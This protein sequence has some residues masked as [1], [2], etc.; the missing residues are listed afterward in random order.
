M[1][2][3]ARIVELAAEERAEMEDVLRS[4]KAASGLSRRARAVLLLPATRKRV[5]LT[6]RRSAG[7]ASGRD[8][9]LC[10]LCRSEVCGRADVV[11][12]RGSERGE[13]IGIKG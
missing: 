2:N 11:M 4:Q 12:Q 9:W 5:F 13:D 10:R 6:L 8:R 7:E 3:R 1:A